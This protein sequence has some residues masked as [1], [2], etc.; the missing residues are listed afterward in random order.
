MNHSPEP[1]YCSYGASWIGLETDDH[2]RKAWIVFHRDDESNPRSPGPI[3]CEMIEPSQSP[4]DEN[5]R[6]IVAAVNFCQHL[7]TELI[8]QLTAA[9]IRP[10]TLAQW[11]R[12]NPTFQ[13]DNDSGPYG[14]KFADC[15]QCDHN[16][17]N[18]K[19]QKN[20]LLDKF[21]QLAKNWT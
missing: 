21:L 5:A 20:C 3:I 14:D 10:A 7:P 13:G 4:Q 6:R 11:V 18:S 8:E 9:G 1:W 19:H 15:I 16:L 2:D 12:K 17:L